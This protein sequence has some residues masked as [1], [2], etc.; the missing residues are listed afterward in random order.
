VGPG[1]PVARQAITRFTALW[2]RPKPAGA[3]AFACGLDQLE[4]A[5]DAVTTDRIEQARLRSDAQ[6]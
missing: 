5:Q 3:I 4:G 1:Y 2:G 6:F